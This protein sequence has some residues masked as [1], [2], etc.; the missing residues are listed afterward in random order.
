MVEVLS[1][2]LAG[3]G[4]GHAIGRMYDEWDRPQDVGHFHLALDPE[5]LVGHDRFVALLDGLLAELRSIAPAP[6]FDEVLVAGD[7]ERRTQAARERH[8][9][10][11]GP[12]LWASLETLSAELHVEVPT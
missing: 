12:A 8:G 4:V 9:I 11:L 3:A 1:G 6:G 10:P 2:V 5:R 7:P